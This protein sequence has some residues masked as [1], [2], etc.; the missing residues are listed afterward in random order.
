MPHLRDL[1]IDR[2]IMGLL[3]SAARRRAEIHLISCDACRERVEFS[4]SFILSMSAALKSPATE[5]ARVLSAGG[6]S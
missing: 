1:T 4:E 2:F 5:K 6:H 3:G